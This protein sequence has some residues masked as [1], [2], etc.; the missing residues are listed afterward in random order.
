MR[1]FTKLLVAGLFCAALFTAVFV[2]A[3]D[4]T[5]TVE[6]TVE[7]TSEPPVEATVET[8]V[9]ATSEATGEATMEATSETTAAP[10]SAPA[11]SATPAPGTATAT[12]IPA[13]TGGRVNANGMPICDSNL[14]LDLYV[15]EHFFGFDGVMSAAMNNTTNPMTPVDV[16]QLDKGQYAALFA[17][18]I[19]TVPPT[20]M[21]EEQIQSAASM[22]TLDDTAFMNQMSTMMPPGTD[23]TNMTMLTSA[24]VAGEEPACANLRHDL[25]RFFTIVAFQ[26]IMPQST[27]EVTAAAGTTMNLSTT[28]LG[29]NEVPGPGDPDATGMSAVT[30]DMANSQVCYNIA[31]Q[32]ITLPATMAHIHRGA[33]GVKGDVVIPFSVAPDASGNATG[34]EKVDPALLQEIAS[35]PAGFYVNV[36]NAD[37]PDGAA[38]GQLAG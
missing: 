23:M 33:V 25:D 38:R 31:I 21:T 16:T 35:N 20:V 28:L 36:H 17:A 4:A 18:P 15:A 30:L 8:T 26:S 37:F 7:A 27:P 14:I 12:L 10:T 29:A 9:E 19:T 5:P 11:A 13:T 22:M 32:N 3:Q 1:N 2:G 6:A 24:A 34:C